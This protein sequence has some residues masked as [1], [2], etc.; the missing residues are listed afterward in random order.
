MLAVGDF[1]QIAQHLRARPCA[2]A[3]LSC[4][5]CKMQRG[6]SWVSGLARVSRFSH[7]SRSSVQ[8]IGCRFNMPLGCMVSSVLVP[9]G[10]YP[11]WEETCAL[12][13][14]RCTLFK[15]RRRSRSYVL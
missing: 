8:T 13:V 6:L 9:V 5:A 7:F 14:C 2:L 3:S 12:Q 4:Q 15:L 10:H 1:S 11:E